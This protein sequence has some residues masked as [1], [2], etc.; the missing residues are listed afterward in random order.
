[1]EDGR[2]WT[3]DCGRWTVDGGLWTVDG[4]WFEFGGTLGLFLK[5]SFIMLGDCLWLASID[6]IVAKK[7]NLFRAKKPRLKTIYSKDN[8]QFHYLR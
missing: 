3:V 4:R 5:F 6:L 8:L 7:N 2:R 1:M